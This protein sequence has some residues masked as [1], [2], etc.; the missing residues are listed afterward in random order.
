MTR[1]PQPLNGRT[2]YMRSPDA[3]TTGANAIGAAG[4][5]LGA[6]L[7]AGTLNGIIIGAGAAFLLSRTTLSH[8]FY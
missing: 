4:A 5:G 6:G 2:V 1:P 3:S 7:G 8:Y